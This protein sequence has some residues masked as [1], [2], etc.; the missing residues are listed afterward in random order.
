MH[1]FSLAK[2]IVEIT[3]K[4][5]EKANKQKVTKITLEIGSLSGVEETALIT[6]LKTLKHN[7]SLEPATIEIRHTKGR[8][9][10]EECHNEFEIKEFF[11]LCPKCKG[12]EKQIL[13]GKEFNI[14][15]IEAE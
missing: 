6:A 15:S 14:I 9:Y 8:A 10:C 5:V 13:S 11:S 7:T 2:E 4:S 12:Y 3:Q 1:E